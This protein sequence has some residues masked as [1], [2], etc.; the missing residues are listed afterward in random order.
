MGEGDVAILGQDIVLREK[1][2]LQ[3]LLRLLPRK[4]QLGFSSLR[5]KW[6]G[7]SDKGLMKIITA[8]KTNDS[9]K[10]EYTCIDVNSDSITIGCN[11]GIVFMYNRNAKTLSRFICEVSGT[12][13]FFVFC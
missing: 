13:I 5:E 4:A 6:S 11:L 7:R 10:V 3:D 2:A 12:N 8:A 1:D 9:L